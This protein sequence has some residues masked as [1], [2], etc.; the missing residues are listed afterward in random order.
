MRHKLT[1]PA[2]LS[3]NSICDTN[4]GGEGRRQNTDVRNI[5]CTV[6]PNHFTN[7][8][9]AVFLRTD[10]VQPVFL[11][12]S[13]TCTLELRNRKGHKPPCQD[14]SSAI[15]ARN[16]FRMSKNAQL[17]EICL[18]L[19]QEAE[20]SSTRFPRV[21]HMKSKKMYTNTIQTIRK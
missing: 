12:A 7:A 21:F 18:V 6:F 3:P 15:S 16:I 5:I 2:C 14:T 20:A 17:G 19:R 10:A 11:S 8:K 9:S 4:S 1:C 13:W